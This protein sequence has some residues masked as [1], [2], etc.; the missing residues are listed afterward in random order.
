[1][2]KTVNFVRFVERDND[3]ITISVQGQIEK[4]K[5]LKMIE[6]TSERK[7]MSI[8][9]K[10][11]SDGKVLNF[12]KGA[13]FAIVPR[14]EKGEVEIIKETT[15]VLDEQANKGLR[16]LMFAVK[17]L[18][19]DTT[20]DSLKDKPDEDIENGLKFLGG[21]GLEDLL[22]DNVAECIRDLREASIKVWMLTG[23]KKETANNIAISCGLLDKTNNS[24]VNIDAENKESLKKQFIEAFKIFEDQDQKYQST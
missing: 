6:F 22:Q 4:Y 14:L 7:R 1:M 3:N 9:V 16:T 5:I 21:T 12:I 18:P 23:D 2:A 10:R 17:E 24:T 11:E 20:A 13:D 19:S 8:V 15:E